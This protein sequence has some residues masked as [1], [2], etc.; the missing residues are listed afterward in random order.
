MFR[1]QNVYNENDEYK[2]ILMKNVKAQSA[3]IPKDYIEE[4]YDKFREA[5][6]LTIQI[7][8]Y[9][10]SKTGKKEVN[11]IATKF[12]GKGQ[13][14]NVLYKEEFIETFI[15]T[16]MKKTDSYYGSNSGLRGQRV[17]EV[18]AYSYEKTLEEVDCVLDNCTVQLYKEK[19]AEKDVTDGIL[20]YFEKDNP[21]WKVKYVSEDAKKQFGIV[22]VIHEDKIGENI[23]INRMSRPVVILDT[24]VSMLL[25][26]E[27]KLQSNL[28]DKNGYALLDKNNY[29]LNDKDGIPTVREGVGETKV[30]NV[31]DIINV[32]VFFTGVNFYSTIN[33][34]LELSDVKIMHEDIFS[35]YDNITHIRITYM[36]TEEHRHCFKYEFRLEDGNTIHKEVEVACYEDL[37]MEIGNVYVRYTNG[38]QE[39]QYATKYR[40]FEKGTQKWLKFLRENVE[41]AYDV[42]FDFD[43]YNRELYCYATEE[44]G[45]NTGIKLTYQNYLEEMQIQPDYDNVVS[46]LWVSSEKCKISDVNPT[47]TD[48]IYD[49][50][51]FENNG[52]L[53]EECCEAL[54]RYR[55]VV[56]TSENNLAEL[57]ANR[58]TAVKRRIRLETE[59]HEK[60]IQYSDVSNV[61]AV[62]IKE[63]NKNKVAEYGKYKADF[64]KEITQLIYMISEQKD[65]IE[66]LDREIDTYL[67]KVSLETCYDENGQIFNE[68][69][70]TELQLNTIEKELKDESFLVAQDLYDYA[71]EQL[72]NWNGVQLQL[73]LSINGLKERMVIPKDMSW[74]EIIKVGNFFTV[75]DFEEPQ[76]IVG[77]KYSPKEDTIKNIEL[78]NTL[79]RVDSYSKLNDLSVVLTE[80]EYT[81]ENMKDIWQ[82]SADVNDFV[83]KMQT[84]YLDN[85]A[86]GIKGRTQHSILDMTSGN[87]YI[88]DAQD[89]NNAVFVGSS[90][91]AIT[92]TGWLDAKLAITADGIIANQL[93]GQVIL[94]QKLYVTSENGE[95]YIGNM[96]N[97]SQGFG[98]RITD[99]EQKERVFLGTELVNGQRKARLRL[100]NRSG[101]GLNLSEEGIIQTY[102]WSDRDHV[103]PYNRANFYF[104]SDSSVIDYKNVYMHIVFKPYRVYSK[105]LSAGGTVNQHAGTSVTGGGGSTTSASGGG[106]AGTSAGG[107]GYAGTSSNGGGYSSSYSVTSG[108]NSTYWQHVQSDPITNNETN[109]NGGHH[110]HSIGKSAFNHTHDVT[111]SVNVP[112][113][114]HNV[115]IP[116]HSHYVQIPSHSHYV[117]IP[118]HSHTIDLS[119]STVHTHNI[120]YGIIDLGGNENYPSSVSLII[121]GRWVKDYIQNNET[122]DIKNYISK[123]VTTPNTIQLT[124]STKG[125]FHVSF[126]VKSFN[127]FE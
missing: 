90:I 44:V 32:S 112:A 59:L 47:G 76:R 110:Y 111:I 116:S 114:S 71:L 85:V 53:T 24:D 15:I 56:S 77:V 6:K 120:E 30:K 39:P 106:Y 74:N 101:Q 109:V 89:K 100:Y 125:V 118:P 82:E 57:R 64:E 126:F 3:I 117:E 84:T 104:W 124:S 1:Q 8:Y 40:S 5:T 50:S 42:I 60:E 38:L 18:E 43:T 49:F 105:S 107:G 115:Q 93:I 54:R 25:A 21:L 102:Q 81:M 103:D 61:L 2:Y 45:K 94:G 95:F 51:Y 88:T 37:K 55:Q 96:N 72:N 26:G 17:I 20:N 52:L 73:D 75:I 98:L 121:N 33:G 127:S 7:P 11:K 19:N 80:A 63:D 122:I 23:T 91:I 34:E 27:V 62:Y 99:S 87:I 48:Y 22:D 69:L 78:S 97:N 108:Q 28:L 70:L 68:E 113:H 31:E 16:D 36:S 9:I 29:L 46:K 58:N 83:K 92:N 119:F 65:Y 13:R 10:T 35:S 14:I 66:S 67:K 79:E 12:L 86:T 123:G 4:R 41:S